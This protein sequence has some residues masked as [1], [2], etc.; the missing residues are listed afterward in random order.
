[1]YKLTWILV[2]FFAFTLSALAAPVPVPQE[3]QDLEARTTHVGRGTWYEP[4]LGNCGWTNS[5]SDLVVAMPKSLYDRNNGSNCGQKVQI[6]YKG[7]SVTAEMV[8][9]CP[10]C[11]GN[12]LDM[13]PSTFQRLAPLSVGVIQVSW[14]FLK[15]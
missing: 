4:G 1:M 12:D 15:K 11:G 2:A 13:S 7:K 10:S 14:H 8:D 9:S 5:R 6:S 3:S